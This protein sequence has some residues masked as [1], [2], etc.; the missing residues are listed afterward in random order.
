MNSKDYFTYIRDFPHTLSIFLTYTL[1]KA[2]VDKI[3]ENSSGRTIIIHDLNKG[4][5][6]N[7]NYDSRLICIP[8]IIP[9][10][11]SNCFHSKLALL[12][13]ESKFR[14]LM[15]SMNLTRSS[16]SSGR[17]I[18]YQIDIEHD[19]IEFLEVL[20]ILESIKIPD[21]V[22][23]DF[24]TEIKSVSLKHLKTNQL[25]RTF[26]DNRLYSISVELLNRVISGENHKPIIRIATPFLSKNLPAEYDDF[27]KK[28]NPSE[29]KLF[30]RESSKLSSVFGNSIIP[31][32]VYK[33][34]K[35]KSKNNFHAKMVMVD[36]G[37]KIILY[38]GS[39]NFT[40]QGFFKSLDKDGNQECGVILKISDEKEINYIRE[41][42]E[43]GWEKPCSPEEWTQVEETD[44]TD[45]DDKKE[46]FAFAIRE[47]K[48]IKLFINIPEAKFNRLSIS[49]NGKKC[50]VQKTLE[51]FYTSRLKN[52][53][54]QT[55]NLK[56]K[57]PN[58]DEITVAIF[59]SDKY[60]EWFKYDG[61][62][63][64]SYQPSA[65][66]SVL[67]SELSKAIEKEGI[68]I[69]GDN[70]IIIEP[71]KLEQFYH[72]VRRELSY[73]KRRKFF[74]ELHLL[75]LEDK[76]KSQSGG[77]GM[78]LIMQFLKAFQRLESSHSFLKF[79]KVCT[80]HLDRC[81]TELKLDKKEF[82]KFYN[83]WVEYE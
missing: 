19:S 10:T 28:L 13:G 45:E 78:Y 46:T 47:N 18:C 60:K 16:F 31:V 71:P 41:W 66:D 33:P 75:E 67:D 49:V 2:V 35:S 25:E 74:S 12:K 15:G 29:I 40:E 80:Q 21:G 17:E 53:S 61:D 27:I 44:T 76:L 8:A 56:I 58:Y 39:A 77:M 54:L 9:Q 64:F 83:R 68:R 51:G 43:K 50:N 3:R 20:K 72:N 69:G 26:I 23:L 14:V 55:E 36:Y 73:I 6:L 65:M 37:K 57:I 63:L 11:Y 24:L 34:V 38:L 30:T 7:E 42:F 5:T 70:N 52:I 81:L 4:V 62:S 82:Y 79:Q 59:N 48:S 22:N 1:E 32:E